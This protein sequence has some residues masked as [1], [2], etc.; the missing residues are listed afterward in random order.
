VTQ[1]YVAWKSTDTL[2]ARINASGRLIAPNLRGNVSVVAITPTGIADTTLV[3]FA[4]APVIITADSGAGQVGVVGDSLATLFVARVKGA[5]SLGI[6][7]IGVRFSAVT[8]GGAVRDTLVLTDLNGRARTRALLGTGAGAYTFTAEVVGVAL[9]PA[10]FIATATPTAASAIA[11]LSGN[12]QVDTIGKL[13]ALPLTVVSDG[14]GCFTV[15]ASIGA[16]HDRHVTG[17]GKAAVLNEKFQ[18]V[19]TLMGVSE[20]LCVRRWGVIS[21]LSFGPLPGRRRR[22]G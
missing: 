2:L 8:A 10:T 15:A 18:A 1:F 11:I 7:G 22:P 5:D 17:G 3:T 19:N 13:L 14:L 9:T 4:P 21:L 16:V 12:A 6:S 20:F